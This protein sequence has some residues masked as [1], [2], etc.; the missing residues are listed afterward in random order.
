MCSVAPAGSAEKAC[1]SV[2][3]ALR[4]V[5]RLFLLS[6]GVDPHAA[7][8]PAI[9]VARETGVQRIVKL[10]ALG[11]HADATNSFL[12][13]HA[14]A[15]RLLEDSGLEWT[16]VRPTFFM[17]NWLLYSAPAIRAGQPVYSNTGQS[18]LAWIDTRDIAEVVAAALTGDEHVGRV[19]DLTG[20]EALSYTQVT[21][22][23]GKGLQRTVQHIP[24]S[25][26]AA[27]TAMAAGMP[28]AYAFALTTLN[29]AVRRGI[30]ETTTDTVEL[31]TGRPARTMD[32]FLSEHLGEFR[33]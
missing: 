5:T 21:E 15:E 14:R 1:A 13:G 30:A 7:E 10:S 27:Y 33:G 22:R 32:A 16:S 4:G 29:Q 26:R 24:V 31:V 12:R 6:S 2:R 23:I 3:Q 8:A 20:P 9:G 18:R 11:S 17:Q 25:D 28:A 19:L